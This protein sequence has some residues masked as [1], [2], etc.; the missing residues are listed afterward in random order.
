MIK[1]RKNT[2]IRLIILLVA[3]FFS[4][5]S[6]AFF[7]IHIGQ[8]GN[9]PN[10]VMY[11]AYEG[12]MFDRT[13]PGAKTNEIMRDANPKT[14]DARI[15][16]LKQ[17]ELEV[18]QV[19]EN[20]KSPAFMRMYLVFDCGKRQYFIKEAEAIARNNVPH[21]SSRA[22]WQAVPNNWLD[23][24]HFVA[25]EEDTWRQAGKDDLTESRKSG[26][27]AQ[28]RM[29]A[30]GLAMVGEWG[31]TRAEPE[32]DNFTWKTFWADG[33]RPPFTDKRTPKEEEIYQAHIARNKLVQAE[34]QKAAGQIDTMTAGIESQLKGMDAETQFQQEIA[35]NFKKKGSK[36]YSTFKGLTEEQLVD[37][38]GVPTTASTHGDL[39]LLL[40]RYSKDDRGT[41]NVLDG[42]GNKVGEQQVGHLLHC[43]VTFKLR[44]GGN[45]PQYRVVDIDMNLDMVHEGGLKKAECQ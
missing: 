18:L 21:K 14:I 7:W 30:L 29:Q 3:A 44:V 6:Y 15:K 39:R 4:S 25:C 2:F 10:R 19:F 1:P 12:W 23:R 26:E 11:Y 38:R 5:T 34:N 45:K 37:V 31:G 42:N 32:V 27:G 9:K 20:P 40:Y 36:Y 43:D 22:E 33:S 35:S 13:D 8:T 28:P 17:V 41:A 16:A 24:A